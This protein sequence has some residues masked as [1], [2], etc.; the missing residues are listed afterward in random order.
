MSFHHPNV[1]A[2]HLQVPDDH[3]N[4]TII[5]PMFSHLIAPPN[6]VYP[7]APV[8]PMAHSFPF[9]RFN[10]D[11]IQFNTP[12]IF[13]SANGTQKP[14]RRTPRKKTVDLLSYGSLH[15]AKQAAFSKFIDCSGNQLR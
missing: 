2:Y 12:T 1:L 3:T 8:Y 7:A 14:Q 11:P 15:D 10:V 4:R 13:P 9:Q 6:Q 5:V